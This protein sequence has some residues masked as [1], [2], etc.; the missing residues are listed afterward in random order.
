MNK[1]KLLLAIFAALIGVSLVAEKSEARWSN[2]TFRTLK[3]QFIVTLGVNSSF[4]QIA[5]FKVFKCAGGYPF[6]CAF[7]YKDG[8]RIPNSDIYGMHI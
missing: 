1:V 3:G 7:A 4:A 8:E 2:L 5:S 6:I